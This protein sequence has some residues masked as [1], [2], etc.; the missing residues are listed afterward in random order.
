MMSTVV[1][2]DIPVADLGRAEKWYGA[3]LGESPHR[4]EFPGFRFSVLPHG[5]E[6]VG[7]CIVEQTDHPGCQNGPTIYLNANGRLEEAT[8]AAVANGGVVLQPPHSIAPHGHRA[9]VL[10]SEGNKVALHSR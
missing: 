4:Q 10:D 5:D 6:G 2:V 8:A 9:V 1:W 3:V 7:G